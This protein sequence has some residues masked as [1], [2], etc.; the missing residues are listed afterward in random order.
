MHSCN[1]YMVKG[2]KEVVKVEELVGARTGSILTQSR[3]IGKFGR[4]ENIQSFVFHVCIHAH[5]AN[6]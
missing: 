6:S 2:R 5:I 4:E 1:R 3:E